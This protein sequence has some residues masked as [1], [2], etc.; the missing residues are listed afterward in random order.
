MQAVDLTAEKHLRLFLTESQPEKLQPVTKNRKP[1]LKRDFFSSRE[2]AAEK[3][4]QQVRLVGS[5][6]VLLTN[7]NLFSG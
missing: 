4:Q 6:D 3:Q 2:A 7:L 1:F 5:T